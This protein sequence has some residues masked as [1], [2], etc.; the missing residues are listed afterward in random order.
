MRERREE[1]GL[2]YTQMARRT[3]FSSDQ[4]RRAATGGSVPR[5]EVV[6]AYAESCDARLV[7]AEKLW[8]EA[9]YQQAQEE[10]PPED[11]PKHTVYVRD[12]A[13]LHLALLDLYRKNGSRPY[14]ELE[15]SSGGALKRSTV[16]CVLQEQIRPEFV[17]AFA[18]E[19]GVRGIALDQW[20]HAW[21]R[22]E[23]R[24]TG[25]VSRARR[26]SEAYRIKGGRLGD[27]S[28]D[29]ARHSRRS[30]HRG[31]RGTELQVAA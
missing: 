6:L 14:R 15:E 19:W 20:G 12:F 24:R 4:L 30:Q 2:T 8:R 21:D 9:R 1:A 7:E 17:S 29:P 28:G 18:E 26:Q 3:D 31:V 11:R 16:W 5:R 23:E 13:D 25:G 10:H 22:A 27:H